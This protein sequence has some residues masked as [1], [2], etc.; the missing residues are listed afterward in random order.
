MQWRKNAR[1]S[2]KNIGY[3]CTYIRFQCLYISCG[4][5][6]KAGHTLLRQIVA[7]FLNTNAREYD[8]LYV[9]NFCVSDAQFL[10]SDWG[11]IVYFGKGLSYR[12]AS[13]RDSYEA[14]RA[15]TTFLYQSRP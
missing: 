12:P 2:C 6:Y 13:L 8:F 7:F 5:Q 4:R 9:S 10:V 11:D 14:L 3:I 15:G 1:C